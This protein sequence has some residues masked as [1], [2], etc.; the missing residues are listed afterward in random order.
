MFGD[1]IGSGAF[2]DLSAY[3][4]VL[5]FVEAGPNGW[6]FT[7]YDQSTRNFPIHNERVENEV[8]GRIRAQSW[9]EAA[10]FSAAGV[11]VRWIGR[12]EKVTLWCAGCGA[13]K[14]IDK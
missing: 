12:D 8:D 14:S 3:S 4:N 1:K 5:L 2:A 6:Y 9:A 10:G 7:A 11:P 13:P